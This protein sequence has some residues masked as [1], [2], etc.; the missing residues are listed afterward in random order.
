MW[1]TSLFFLS[2]MGPGSGRYSQSPLVRTIFDG[3]LRVHPA[4][5][6][7]STWKTY[8]VNGVRRATSKDVTL[9]LV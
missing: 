1:Y 7:A 3:A 8:S 9:F 5:V 6:Q 2:E 4:I